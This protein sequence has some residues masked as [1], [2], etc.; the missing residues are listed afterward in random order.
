[1]PL[2]QAHA[3]MHA[4]GLHLPLPLQVPLDQY[5]P[6]LV[7]GAVPSTNLRRLEVEMYGMQDEVKKCFSCVRYTHA[8]LYIEVS[9]CATCQ[10]AHNVFIAASPALSFWWQQTAAATQSTCLPKGKLS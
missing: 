6:P 8:G 7:D 5:V 10:Q 4:P 3:F 9:A 1:M 2:L